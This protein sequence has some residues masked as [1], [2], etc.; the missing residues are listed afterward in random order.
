[1]ERPHVT[2]STQTSASLF[3]KTAALALC[4]QPST[5]LN[6]NAGLSAS[7]EGSV[8]SAGRAEQVERSRTPTWVFADPMWH[9]K[10]RLLS[11]YVLHHTLVEMLGGRFLLLAV[12]AGLTGYRNILWTFICNTDRANLASFGTFSRSFRKY[13]TQPHDTIYYFSLT[14][15]RE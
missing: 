3:W 5:H 10:G 12:F 11:N 2:I 13:L 9:H 15:S 6:S 14:Q 4:L 1:M 8:E 7:L